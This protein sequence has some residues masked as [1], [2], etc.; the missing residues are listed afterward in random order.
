MSA[1]IVFP[2][3]DWIDRALV[4]SLQ[5]SAFIMESTM[6]PYIPQDTGTL[7]Q[8][9]TIVDTNYGFNIEYNTDYAQY[10]YHNPRMKNMTT[11]GTTPFWD[12]TYY[13]LSDGYEAFLSAVDGA[14][15]RR[16]SNA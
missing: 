3:D 16:L 6:E 15:E 14:L 1:T 5:D 11:P 9:S 13:L 10:V 4:E 7:R 2:N 12:D 8:S